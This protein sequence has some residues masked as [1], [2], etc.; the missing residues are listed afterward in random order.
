MDRRACR[1]LSGIAM[2]RYL[3]LAVVGLS[4]WAAPAAFGQPGDDRPGPGRPPRDGGGR[5]DAEIERLRAQVRELEKKL[6]TV[7]ESDRR[8][9]RDTR[10]PDGPGRPGPGRDARGSDGPGRPGMA[11]P[12]DRGPRPAFRGPGGPE[13]RG[14]RSGPPAGPGRG[15]DEFRREPRPGGGSDLTR[16]IDRIIRELEDI[17]READRPQR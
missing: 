8:P 5:P 17:R 16:R 14:D 6:A 11:P 4:L 9:D 7:R 1:R 10:G 12:G 3:S 15:P 2:K 13:G